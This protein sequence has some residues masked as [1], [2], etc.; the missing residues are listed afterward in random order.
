MFQVIS[1]IATDSTTLQPPYYREH[2]H[3][4][5]HSLSCDQSGKCK[6]RWEKSPFCNATMLTKI[7]TDALKWL[8]LMVFNMI[9]NIFKQHFIYYFEPGN[10]VQCKLLKEAPEAQ[11]K[12]QFKPLRCNSKK[13]TLPHNQREPFPPRAPNRSSILINPLKN[14]TE[15]HSKFRKGR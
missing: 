2:S 10:P 9:L 3:N 1:N 13:N 7:W 6:T 8:D 15:V 4:K 14:M 5:N 12:T 11:S